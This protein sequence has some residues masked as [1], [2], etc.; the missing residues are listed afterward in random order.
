[1]NTED[2]E[3]LNQLEG[4]LNFSLTFASRDAE[5]LKLFNSLGARGKF[6]AEAGFAG[7][8]DKLLPLLATLY[9][10][11]TLTMPIFYKASFIRE[12]EVHFGKTWIDKDYPN[13]TAPKLSKDAPADGDDWWTTELNGLRG[14]RRL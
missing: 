11:F 2:L 12:Y 7:T 10:S 1:M 3:R 13:L 5:L 6:W 8:P 9:E 14:Y 4:Y